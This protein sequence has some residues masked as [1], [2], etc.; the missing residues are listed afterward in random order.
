MENKK[1]LSVDRLN[2]Y[3]T[4]S[5]KLVKVLDN[6]SFDVY[7][8]D[9][10][11]IIG[12]S[13]S[14][15]ST[16]GKCIIR[17]Y[18]SSSGNIMFD[19]IIINQDKM[20]KKT[21]QWLYQNMSMIFQD[22][23]SSLNGRKNVLSIISEPLI[24]NKTIQKEVKE[25]INNCKLVNQF[26]QNTYKWQDYNFTKEFL[27]PFINQNI[28][29]MNDGIKKVAQ[30][31]AT[32]IQ[33]LKEIRDTLVDTEA[34]YKASLN[35]LNEY[36]YYIK[37][38][39]VFNY[40]NYMND[41]L[42]DTEI[43]YRH[44]KEELEHEERLKE[45]PEQYWVLDKELRELKSAYN[46]YLTSN[47]LIYKQQNLN[48]L[49]S[50][51]ARYTS[52]IKSLKQNASLTESITENI[53]YKTDIIILNDTLQAIN[54]LDKELYV[55]ENEIEQ[56]SN[57]I[58]EKIKAKYAH[59]TSDIA[60]LGQLSETIDKL[61]LKDVE[62]QEIRSRFS[63]YKTLYDKIIDEQEKLRD[64][65]FLVEA[66]DIINTVK[67]LTLASAENKRAVKEKIHNYENQ[68]HHIETK[69]SMLKTKFLQQQKSR[70]KEYN[71]AKFQFDKANHKR[72]LWMA[73]DN[74]FF[75]KEKL[76]LIDEQH[77][78]VADHLEKF[79]QLQVELKKLVK[80]KL[81]L[82]SQTLKDDKK[83][84][85][86]LDIIIREI[87]IKAL[88]MDAINFEVDTYFEDLKLYRRLRSTNKAVLYS[89]YK[90]LKESLVR[91]YVYKALEE[92]GLKNE[93]AYR[94][95]HEFSGGQRQRIVIA[96]ALISKPKL[97]IADE[98]ISALD[99]SIQAQVINIMKALAN[100]YGITFLFIA[101][102]LS[103]V[104]YTSNRLI[105]MHKGKIVEKGNTDE[106]FTNPI[107][108]Y[109]KSLI[110]ASPELS[111]IHVDLASFSSKLDYDKDYS[112]N[113][114][115]EFYAVPGAKEHFV[116]ATE[117]QFKKWVK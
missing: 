34:N 86:D 99:V 58:N 55:D 62:E 80:E 6:I 35:S 63:E 85:N 25:V 116:Y 47:N 53:Q 111:K 2:K 64:T 30:I 95:P 92:V 82:V 67:K 26:F 96:R 7:E 12:E 104:R 21:K 101:H 56:F 112:P 24:I 83:V 79:Y 28:D 49:K 44:A 48:R 69:M 29:N 11:G 87:K 1:L 71:S 106:V 54:S 60:K 75:D 42:H 3:F 16:T 4:K 23:M 17:L 8:K 73:Q 51:K 46:E 93:H 100:K 59:L 31:Q 97:V 109:T 14:G 88:T 90:K 70:E 36:L 66:P 114:I 40:E 19:D 72:E 43:N 57:F 84:K 102:D 103:M 18:S 10:L 52:E 39:H 110:K 20:P 61:S 50:I 45:A 13:G 105:I 115:P 9:F 22:P 37:L 5:G 76:P 94:Y 89:Q 81:K 98:P 27:I 33:A 15:K 117:R 108:P 91:S 78:W 74:S 77:Q 38:L 41:K 32:S 65:D 113:N 107:H 68:I